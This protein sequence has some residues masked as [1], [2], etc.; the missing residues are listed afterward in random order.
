MTDE[1]QKDPDQPVAETEPAASPD[2]GA[3]A[4]QGVSAATDGEE[5]IAG[6]M[7][8]GDAP[9]VDLAAKA[10]AAAE[11]AGSA[12]SPDRATES[13]ARVP[14]RGRPQP[15]ANRGIDV[16]LKI[17]LVVNLVLLG[18]IATLPD[19]ALTGPESVTVS[20]AELAKPERDTRFEPKLNRVVVPR[21]DRW[22]QALDASDSGDYQRAIHLLEESLR[23][24]K[25]MAE[26]YRRLVYSQLSY[27]AQKDGNMELADHYLRK[28]NQILRRTY[29]PEDL[30]R[31]ARQAEAA[32]DASQMRAAYARFLLQQGMVPASERQAIHEAYLKLGDSYRI[33]AEAGASGVAKPPTAG[34]K[35]ADHRE[36][37]T[38]K[39]GGGG[40]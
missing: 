1:A 27:C 10:A 40:H 25:N 17:A 3:V 32:G 14:I 24:E 7:A 39:H 2:D 29:L 37:P 9:A 31:S 11:S 6:L 5:A 4:T 38:T 33:Q 36:A 20:T 26:P 13:V 19:H 21:S 23:L 8:G 15:L 35:P 12:D 30:L 16:G 18:I 28:A 22:I 34:A